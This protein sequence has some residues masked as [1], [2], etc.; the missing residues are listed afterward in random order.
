MN[1]TVNE[2]RREFL[3]TSAVIGGG[4]ALE[5]CI[6]GMLARAGTGKG[7]EVTAWVVI[8]PDETLTFVVDLVSIDRFQ[9]NEG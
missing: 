1:Q 3:R 9:P 4:L 5:F 7:S 8:Q 6:P 2:S